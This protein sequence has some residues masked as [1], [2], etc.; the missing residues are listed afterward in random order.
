MGEHVIGRM[1]QTDFE[2]LKYQ[3]GKDYCSCGYCSIFT[4]KR[5]CGLSNGVQDWELVDDPDAKCCGGLCNKQ[6][7]C[8]RPDPLSCTI[9][10]GPNK[11]NPLLEAT[12][13]GTA[14]NL[15]C[16]FDL[17]KIVTKDQVDK[18]KAKFGL[19]NDVE[20][21][22]CTQKVTTCPDGERECSRIF[23]TGEGSTECRTW[24]DAQPSEAKD[25][26]MHNYCIRHNTSDCRCVNR[27]IADSYRAMKGAKSINDGCWF[28][29]CANPSKHFVP[30]HLVK[31]TCPDK[32]CQQLFDFM[33]VE[34]INISD[35]KND[36]NCDFSGSS[37][38]G[39]TPVPSNH[40]NILIGVGLVMVGVLVLLVKRR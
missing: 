27:S 10:L 32:I 7:V 18:F 25:A 20:A 38:S 22:Y 31:P 35:V 36:I 37:G 5:E 24:F 15:K 14:P 19:N 33:N 3:P 2:R 39:P 12:W 23:S 16:T 28:I 9:G 30:S 40:L 34:K 1:R 21:H 13:D 17:D 29:P 11:E 8:V 6:P 26:I 4:G